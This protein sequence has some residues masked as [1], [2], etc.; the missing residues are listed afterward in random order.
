MKHCI[1]F[2]SLR[3]DLPT[4]D[5]LTAMFCTVQYCGACVVLDMLLSAL[6][7]QC[8]QSFVVCCIASSED[9]VWDQRCKR[10]WGQRRDH[11]TVICSVILSFVRPLR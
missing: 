4:S 6:R 10:G 5:S 8:T 7:S 11:H 1:R 9:E 3:A 2:G